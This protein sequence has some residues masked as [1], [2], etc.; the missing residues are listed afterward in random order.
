[1]N[2]SKISIVKMILMG[3]VVFSMHFGGSSM[4]WPMTWGKESGLNIFSAYS[5]IFLTALLF[6]LLGYIAIIRS[7]GTF[8]QITQR[9]SNKF[10]LIFCSLTIL[11]LGPLYT[12]PRMSAAA[13]DAFMQLTGI[14]TSSGIFAILFSFVYYLVVYWFIAGKD[15]VVDKISKILL[16]ILLVSVVAIITKGLIVPLG[17]VAPR[18]YTTVPFIYGFINGYDTAELLCALIF[19][20]III[21]DLKNKNMSN[22]ITKDLIIICCI[23][24]G[25]LS[26]THMGHM[27][28]G[29]KVS[30]SMVG[31]KF[32]ALYTNVVVELWGVVG[33]A[34]FNV[35]LLLAALTTAIGLSLS[36]AEYFSEV[37][38]NK[39]KYKN[40]MI[41][42]LI[43]SAIVSS[44]GLDKIVVLVTPFLKVVYPPA[45][46]L[47]LYYAFAPKKASKR[48]F[49]GFKLSIISAF[50]YG[51]LDG[52]VEF[53][54]MAD[55]M[56]NIL[57]KFY[58][59]IP[60]SE[61]SLGWVPVSGT[62]F[63]IGMA[64]WYKK[65]DN[66][67]KMEVAN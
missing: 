49:H 10:A 17:E 4:I 42:V 55:S 61:F 62:L 29:S 54:K 11:V 21:D 31:L 45:I 15:G 48:L 43:F 60:L 39:L 32:A 63:F 33:G 58:H 8:F 27:I 52:I 23:G 1:M 19:S 5:G 7:E 67:K 30:T 3:G 22:N 40:S 53:M 38:N 36:S 28:I 50:C 14:Q 26:C 35:A 41:M 56:D 37:S 12:I 46:V 6:P 24:I 57:A 65:D 44:L 47:T 64:I 13:W 25:I 2:K 20:T 18:E 51:I 66:D 59:M 16:P 34:I 9:V